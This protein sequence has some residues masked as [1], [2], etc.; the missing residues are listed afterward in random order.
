MNVGSSENN[1]K[2]TPAK[3]LARMI[4]KSVSGLVNNNSMVPVLFSS[5]N[6]RMVMAG[7]RNKNITGA[8]KNNE[9]KVALP[10]SKM[11]SFPEKTH[12]N[13]PVAKRKMAIVTYPIKELRKDR[14]SLIKRALI[15]Q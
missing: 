10:P 5:A 3:Y 14:I 6:E 11:F 4:C 7:I 1:T 13:S 2:I 15:V 9:S 8:L 12:M